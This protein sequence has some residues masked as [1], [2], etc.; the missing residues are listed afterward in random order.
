MPGWRG[1]LTGSSRLAQEARE[2]TAAAAR[3]EEIEAKR[4]E[5]ER[6]R[7]TAEARIA[8]VLRKNV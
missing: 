8:A 3:G 2:K 4:R 6:V 7:Q 1:V 5:L